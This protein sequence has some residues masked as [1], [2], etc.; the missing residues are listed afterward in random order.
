M[1]NYEELKAAVASVIKTNSNQEITGQV[2]QN[3]LTTLISQV[4]A[5]A[6]FAGIATPE[7][8]PGNP[9]QNVFYIAS[10]KGVYINFN[11]YDLTGSMVVFSNT[12][13]SWNAI[14]LNSASYDDFVQLKDEM[15]FSVGIQSNL[16][17]S[18]IRNEDNS[19]DVTFTG[20]II[21]IRSGHKG[22]NLTFDSYPTTFKVPIYMTLCLD[23]VT[24]EVSVQNMGDGIRTPNNLVL[25]HNEP[26]GVFNG[27]FANLYNKN[28]LTNYID[29]DKGGFIISPSNNF[30]IRKD[31]NNIIIKYL[32]SRYNF[33]DEYMQSYNIYVEQNT[34]ITLLPFY[35][36]VLNMN[37]REINVVSSYSKN[38]NKLILLAYQEGGFVLNGLLKGQFDK[39]LNNAP[40]LIN[41]YMDFTDISYSMLKPMTW[42]NSNNVETSPDIYFDLYYFDVENS[43]KFLIY[44]STGG[45]NTIFVDADGNVLSSFQS[46]PKYQSVWVELDVPEGAVLLKVTN[47]RHTNNH[48]LAYPIIAKANHRTN[49]KI[50]SLLSGKK[51]VFFGDS[52]TEQGY[53]V[54][55]FKR[56]TGCIVVNRGSSGTSY[57]KTDA[58]ANSLS[59]R[60]DL[61]SSDAVGG[62]LGLPSKADLI[63]VFAG[64]NDWGYRST[65]TSST[66][67][68]ITLGDITE[69][70]NITTVIGAVKHICSVL[71]NKYP[72][73]KIVVLSP[74][75]C[76]TN[77]SL[78]EW[79][80]IEYTN[81]KSAITF[82]TDIDGNTLSYWRNKIEEVASFYGIYFIDMTKCGFSAFS[83]S[84]NSTFFLDG[85]HP[86]EL[87]GEIMAKY[88]LK[89][90]SIV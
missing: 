35:S 47:A 10:K 27:V 25:L 67:R 6:T 45:A 49:Q 89:Q 75:H 86:N 63:I 51:V 5:N 59:E 42:V 81:E 40:Q 8:V 14:S 69:P 52:I 56:L 36:L 17:V 73:N 30:G 90:L 77:S 13:G 68:K 20:R 31:G 11:N 44:H 16:N 26:I 62:A 55:A 78:L 34:E 19:V 32:S 66:Q 76:Y 53:Y 15:E 38:D 3:T 60:V 64:I 29:I 82:N 33:I 2:L 57:A 28:N 7:T 23:V 37:T 70:E 43:S 1:G 41:D 46:S 83:S 85:L 58:H 50:Q 87:G 61:P 12:T 84:D 88:I 74:M 4:G 18:F 79:R 21:F 39:Q 65:P 9:D 24:K 72:N 80:E 22:F 48:P 54:D 71:R